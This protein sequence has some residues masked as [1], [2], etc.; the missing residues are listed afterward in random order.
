MWFL[1][2]ATVNMS[3]SSLLFSL[4]HQWGKWNLEIVKID[5]FSF[6]HW[7]DYNGASILFCT[8]SIFK[9]TWTTLLPTRQKTPPIIL[10][11]VLLHTQFW[12]LHVSNAGPPC[13]LQH[14]LLA[15]HDT[16]SPGHPHGS[17]FN[18]FR[19][20]YNIGIRSHSTISQIIEVADEAP[21]R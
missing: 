20:Y 19:R 13:H 12:E 3:Q 11:P 7:S 8:E 16:G 1:G 15:L 2:R 4:S 17:L 10:L 9:H 14:K 18:H 21:W 5:I 6:H